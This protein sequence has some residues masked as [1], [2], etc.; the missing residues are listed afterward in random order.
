STSLGRSY[1]G[2]RS[3][4]RRCACRQTGVPLECSRIFGRRSLRRLCFPR[5]GCFRQDENA[6]IVAA[7]SAADVSFSFLPYN[8]ISQ[9]S[10]RSDC[11]DQLG[12]WLLCRDGLAFD[13]RSCRTYS[14]AGAIAPNRKRDKQQIQTDERSHIR[15][16]ANAK[17]VT[18]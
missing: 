9:R 13:C 5:F 3:I 14:N 2:S 11:P 8:N 12:V 16:A 15:F 6:A 10:F 1:S 4:E 7:V 18:M 17:A